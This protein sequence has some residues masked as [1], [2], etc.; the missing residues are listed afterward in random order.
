MFNT[1]LELLCLEIPYLPSTS[2]FSIRNHYYW[3]NLLVV[4]NELYYRRKSILLI[5]LCSY[6]RKM[7]LSK[8]INILKEHI[9]SFIEAQYRVTNKGLF[10]DGRGCS[11]GN[12]ICERFLNNTIIKK[13]KK[14]NK[15]I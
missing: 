14:T 13:T 8:G 7:L 15:Y 6:R 3:C 5:Y 2:T 10:R 4:I 11:F 1:Y 12:T 9:L